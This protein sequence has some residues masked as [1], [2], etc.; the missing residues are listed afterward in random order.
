MVV[1]G[2]C[3]WAFPSYIQECAMGNKKQA[4]EILV[5]IIRQCG[6]DYIEGKTKLFKAF[7]FAHLYYAKSNSDFLSDWPIVRMP[8][9]PGIDNFDELMGELQEEGLVLVSPCQMGPF[10]GIRYD[11]TEEGK[12]ACSPSPE[13]VA[14]IKKTVKYVEHKTA[15]QLSEV[16]HAYSN[17]WNDTSDGEEMNICLDLL[18]EDEYQESRDRTASIASQL[19]ATWK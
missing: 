17:T 16:T 6:G 14:A 10:T 1:Q 7:Y 4:K 2:T 15:E 18:T 13:A 11:V 3:I 8:R 5:E 12:R 9:G 19:D